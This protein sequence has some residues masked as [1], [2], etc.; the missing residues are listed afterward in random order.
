MSI[1]M[2]A[3]PA[4]LLAMFS[5][6]W[7]PVNDWLETY[8]EILSHRSLS[9]ATVNSR[10]F[11]IAHIRDTLGPKPI[12]RIRPVDV[13]RV[14]RE[15]WDSGRKSCARR[16]LIEIRDMFA[17]AVA[18]GVVTTNPAITIRALPYHVM[19]SRLSF[20]L[21]QDMLVTA[22][23]QMAQWVPRLLKLGLIT[24]QRR[25]DLVKMKF[26]DVWDGHL[27]VEQQ[28]TGARIALPLA[29]S[30]E[31]AGLRLGDVI[32]ECRDYDVK[33]GETLLRKKGG[34]PYCAAH[35]TNSF[36]QCLLLTLGG[37]WKGPGTPPS[38]HEMRSLAERLQREHGIDTQTLLGHKRS[39]MTD[40]YND[41]RGLNRERWKCLKLVTVMT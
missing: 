15:I 19:R 7:M 1:L 5:R 8:V 2:K 30:L 39:V 18:A 27:H 38:E 24:G 41:D 11:H 20:E 22:E 36:R 25:G 23:R 32:E 16:V 4:R 31:E 13:S 21:W 9:D 12:G 35:L 26:A 33:P 28:K 40:A 3:R 17:E 29:L 34:K 37:E 14:V 6:R 10:G